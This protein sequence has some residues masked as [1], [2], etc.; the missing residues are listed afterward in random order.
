MTMQRAQSAE[1]S[2][3]V[4]RTSG[5]D[6]RL[7]AGVPR[8][9]R[10]DAPACLVLDVRLPGLSGLDLQREL[11]EANSHVP[12]HFHHR[13]RR[14]SDERA[15]DEGRRGRVSDK[16][17]RDQDLLDAIQLAIERDR[18]ALAQRA[19]IG[20]TAR[21]VRVAYT[22]RTR[23]DGPGRPRHAKQASRRRTG[24]ER[25]HR[26]DAARPSDAQK[27]QRRVPRRA[28]PDGRKAGRSLPRSSSRLGAPSIGMKPI[29]N[30]HSAQ[31]AGAIPASAIV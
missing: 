19:E 15:C 2:P 3:L 13:P 28:G 17:F 25:D 16:P 1:D 9:K 21:P 4:G 31:D 20:R 22:A 27:M 30:M 18:E 10:P 24:H 14:H 29:E 7:R 5:R 11:A 6:L 8:S 12:D 26:K 23:S